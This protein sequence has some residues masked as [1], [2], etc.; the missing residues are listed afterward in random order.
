MLVVDDYQH[1]LTIKEYKGFRI[2]TLRD[3]DELHKRAEGTARDR[4]NNNKKRFI[5]G[6]DYF[7][8][9]T[10]EAKTL[11]GVKA[12]HGLILLT[13]SG[14]LMVV[15]LFSDDLAWKVQRQLVKTYF[16]AKEVASTQSDTSSLSPLLQ[17]LINIE[18]RQNALESA[19]K[20]KA[21]EIEN[22]REAVATMTDN[23]N[24]APDS[25]V[26]NRTINEL[27]RWT[28]LEHEEIYNKAY[29]IFKQKHGIDIPRRVANER[30]KIQ[31][32]RIEKTGKPYAES[33]LKSKVNGL[34][35]MVR[36]ECLDLFH[37]VLVAWLAKEKTKSTLRL[38]Q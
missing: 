25:A 6:E 22:V 4:F 24:R 21:N 5:E 29:D 17:V 14:Y 32:E 33:T 11:F 2:V 9:N 16:K 37:E 12:P 38:V 15:K 28:R 30:Q 26:V 18:T 36:S 10:Y 8:C 19:L 3:V 13:E 23:I 20:D 1:E 7:V 35:I 31:D 34:D 27:C